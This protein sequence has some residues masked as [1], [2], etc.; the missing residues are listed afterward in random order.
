M[1]GTIAKRLRR[2]TQY[3]PNNNSLNKYVKQQVLKRAAVPLEVNKTGFITVARTTLM[4]T[5][6]EPRAKYQR[7]KT[8]YRKDKA[9][10]SKTAIGVGI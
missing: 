2:V 5:R 1:R 8:L 7:A 3:D 6:D 4:L 10:F 9:M